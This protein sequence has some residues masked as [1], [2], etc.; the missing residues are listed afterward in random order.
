MHS[1]RLHILQY[2]EYNAIYKAYNFSEPWNGP[3]N[4]KMTITTIEEFLCPSDSSVRGRPL[5]NYLAVTGPGTVWD[6]RNS[7]PDQWHIMVVEVA[8]SK[9]RWAE[10]RDL[11]IDEACRSVGDGPGPW[12]S[13]HHVISGRFFFHDEAGSN[14]LLSDGSVEFIP[15]GLPPETL[16]GLF[17]GDE[18][19]WQ[20]CEN[21]H[22]ACQWR[23]NWTNMASLAVLIISYGVMLFRPLD[24]RPPEVE[25][26]T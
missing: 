23:I 14:V 19:A 9:I 16:R 1:W 6:S 22:A 3:N 24:K 17:T 10:P 8:N 21:F 13:S 2:M 4:S 5:T 15:A 12:I 20:A 7:I 18:K 11:T 25:P 26:A